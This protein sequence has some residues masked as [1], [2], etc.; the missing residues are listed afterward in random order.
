MS[1]HSTQHLALRQV[2]KELTKHRLDSDSRERKALNQHITIF[3]QYGNEN[4]QLRTT[5]S[6]PQTIASG[7]KPEEF[8]TGMISYTVLRGSW[9]YGIVCVSARSEDK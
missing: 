8:V 4:Y 5:F 2:T 6:V 3:I 1:K 9:C 7:I